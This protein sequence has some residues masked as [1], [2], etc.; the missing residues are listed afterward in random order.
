MSN[1]KT[2][3]RMH[4]KGPAR[5]PI[6]LESVNVF[7]GIKS[8]EKDSA[9]QPHLYKIVS[10]PKYPPKSKWHN[11]NAKT[12]RM[13]PIRKMVKEDRKSLNFLLI[14]FPK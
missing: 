1:G 11:K 7:I 13:I 4:N 9:C 3:T 2:N 8:T 6:F 14:V 5:N 12:D 10:Y